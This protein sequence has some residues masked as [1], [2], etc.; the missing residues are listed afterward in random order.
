MSMGSRIF[1]VSGWLVVVIGVLAAVSFGVFA[2]LLRDGLGPDSVPSHGAVAAWRVFEGFAV[3]G[4]LSVGLFC[5]G[6]ALV[7]KAKRGVSNA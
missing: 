5:A 2:V 4:V 1:T 6:I 7:Q 3:P